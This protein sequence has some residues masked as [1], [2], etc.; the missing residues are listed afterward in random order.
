MWTGF[1]SNGLI[2]LKYPVKRLVSELRLKR[3]IRRL[4]STPRNSLENPVEHTA[5]VEWIAREFEQIDL[6]VTRQVFE[7]PGQHP[8]RKGVNIVASLRTS[9]PSHDRPI[10]VGAHYDTVPNSPG[11]DDNA[12]GVAALLECARVLTESKRAE[13]VIFVAFDAEEAQP[14]V[15]GLHGSTEF[16]SRLSKSYPPAA[17]IVFE[18]VGFSSKTIKQRLP[19]SFRFMFPSTYR[20]LK[21]HCFSANSLLILSR[22]KGQVI[23][24]HLEQIAMQPDILL[25]VLPLKVPP[26]IP[27]VRNLRRSDH[28]PFWVAGIPAVMITD[29]AN[30]RNPHYHQMS[31]AADTIDLQLVAK[32]ARMVVE[33]I[34]RD[35]I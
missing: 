27:L 21:R 15:G 16:V 8:V 6:E 11:A 22:G 31:D 23:S 10:I 30:F 9:S 5:A 20:T 24:D 13:Q 33:V 3:I 12:S 34:K 25:P 32:A 29:T 7:I 28:T 4:A 17:A 35:V 19:G 26:W 2:G 18:S 14:N 1:S